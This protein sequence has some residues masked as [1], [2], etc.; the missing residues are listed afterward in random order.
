MPKADID[1]I[2]A[3]SKETIIDYLAIPYVS[4]GA[5][6]LTIKELLGSNGSIID[7]ISKIDTLEGVQQYENILKHS[8]G[9]IF[10][11]NELQWEFAAEK[12][13]LA[14]KWAIE[15]ANTSAKPIMIQ[16]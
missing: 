5:D 8:D 15:T 4:S 7:V 14:Q 6:P 9:V 16:S 2:Q 11:R 10:V 3:I 12:L 13:M 1:D